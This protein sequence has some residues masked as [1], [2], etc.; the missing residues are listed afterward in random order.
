VRFQRLASGRV[1]SVFVG[2]ATLLRLDPP[3]KDGGVVED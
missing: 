3:P 1:E 2:S